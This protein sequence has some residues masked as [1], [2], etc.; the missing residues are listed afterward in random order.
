MLDFQQY[1]DKYNDGKAPDFITIQL[2]VNDVFLAT[3]ADIQK[4]VN[5]ILKSMDKLI[6]AIRKDAPDAVI[7]IG[8]TTAGACQDAFGSGYKC[9]Q[10]A[11]QF[12]KNQQAI[13]AAYLK[14]V[15]TL[16]DPK[17]VIIPTCLNLDRENNFPL[18]REKVNACSTADV[19]RQDNGVHPAKS[20]GD[21]MG[22]TFF[23]W[24]KYHLN[25]K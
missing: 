4:N 9:G 10:T 23:C 5:G 14:K 20:G 17:L 8:L 2:G 3:D 25:R 13:C 6:D 24:L 11:W 12:R 19:F 22:D 1:F 7:G 16:K 21:Q 15:A 18:I